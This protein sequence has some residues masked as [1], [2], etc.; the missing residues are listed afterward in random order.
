MIYPKT[1]PSV[2]SVASHYNDLDAFY[3]LIWGEHVHH[4]LWKT[5]K[6]SP[7]QATEQLIDLISEHAQFSPHQKVCD[8]GCGYGATSRYLAKQFKVAV[9]GLTVSEKQLQYAQKAP[10]LDPNPQYLLCDFFKNSLPAQTFDSVI[11][12]ESTEHMADKQQFFLE[13]SRL[14]KAKGKCLVYAWLAEEKPT[15]WKIRYLLEPICSEG[16]LPGLATS[17]EYKEW[18]KRAGF[19]QVKYLD[20]SS[21]VKKTWTIC[22]RRALG[23][24]FTHSE[25]RNYIL[26]ASQS[27]RVFAKTL[28]RIWLAYT[29]KTMRYGLFVGQRS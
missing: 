11:A 2:S 25:F 8:V 27:E 19:N 5:G 7:Q 17:E 14:L 15:P 28:L 3:R 22:I 20:L 13:S 26:N 12:I 24:F 23:R 21:N 9:T 6:E 10:K 4:G 29:L 18:M 16:R 1:M